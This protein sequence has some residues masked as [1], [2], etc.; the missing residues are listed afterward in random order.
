MNKTYNELIKEIKSIKELVRQTGIIVDELVK[1]ELEAPIK[2]INKYKDELELFTS[3]KNRLEKELNKVTKY[4]KIKVINE[5]NYEKDIVIVKFDYRST[6]EDKKLWLE[7][8]GFNSYSENYSNNCYYDCS[9]QCCS[10]QV[11]YGKN[12]VVIYKTY[13]V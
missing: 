10:T 7:E 3:K 6:K 11:T 2:L 13:D 9:G 4:G 5:G 1:E 12:K 8:N